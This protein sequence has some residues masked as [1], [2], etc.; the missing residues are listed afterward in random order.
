VFAHGPQ[1][2]INGD[3]RRQNGALFRGS[4][5]TFARWTA[6]CLPTSEFRPD[7]LDTPALPDHYVGKYGPHVQLLLKNAGAS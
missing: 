2:D 6:S 1:A 5:R 7:W 3:L 4:L